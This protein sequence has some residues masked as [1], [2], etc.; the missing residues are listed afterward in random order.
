MV[1]T[2]SKEEDRTSRDSLTVRPSLTM[3]NYANAVWN[4]VGVHA[5]F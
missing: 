4:D 2:I 3:R 1:E 5:I